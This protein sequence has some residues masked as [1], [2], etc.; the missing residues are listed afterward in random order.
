MHNDNKQ[1]RTTDSSAYTEPG[2][3]GA[4]QL[5]SGARTGVPLAASCAMCF[6]EDR[7]RLKHAPLFQHS[8]DGGLLLAVEAE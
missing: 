1:H 8:P 6:E 5:P 4:Y 2:A 7:A 3:S